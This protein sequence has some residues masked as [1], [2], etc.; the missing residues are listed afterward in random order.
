M[1]RTKLMSIAALAVVFAVLLPSSGAW[2]ASKERVLYSF[3]NDGKDGD[4]P[5]A[6]LIFDAAGN[7]YGTTVGGGDHGGGAVFELTPG[8]R[9]RWTEKVLYSFKGGTDGDSPYAG[10]IFDTAGNLY[11]TTVRGGSNNTGTVFE[12]T[13]GTNGQWSE[14]V[15][16]SLI[17]FPYGGLIFDAVGNLYSTTFKSST[18]PGTVFELTPGNGQWNETVLYDFPGFHAA[19]PRAGLIFDTAGNLYGTAIT[20]VHG[21]VFE[22]TPG[23]NGWTEN[24]LYQFNR[25]P[26]GA[27]PLAGL[28]FDASGNLYSTTSA[29][30]T[31]YRGTV[32]EL[33][34]G[35]GGKW[36]ETVLHSFGKGV[37]GQSPQASLILAANGKLYGTT[38]EG[39]LFGVGTVFALTPGAHGQWTEKVVH[40]FG[41]GKDGARPFAGL[42][43]KGGKLYGTTGG[44]GGTNALGTVFELTP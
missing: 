43:E 35:G 20:N 3:K 19:F 16:Y 23:S 22:L 28:I 5:Y 37:D 41:Y 29:G 42:I 10:L 21:V 7:L 38:E 44:G 24:V 6:G 2:A 11:G 33:T 40:S 30:G 17:G 15:L 1:Q 14:T 26:D 27:Y 8:A 18:G 12:L 34:P 25:H 32:F 39:G 4:V 9:G 13:P 36:T 31:H